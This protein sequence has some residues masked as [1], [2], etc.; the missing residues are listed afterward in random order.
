MEDERKR[1]REKEREEGE[2]GLTNI[3]THKLMYRVALSA[4]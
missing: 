1:G 3:H 2:R 4:T